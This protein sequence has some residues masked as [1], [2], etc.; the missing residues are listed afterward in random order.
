[1]TDCVFCKIVSGELPSSKIYEDDLCLAFLDI[2]PVNPGHT[3]LIP[4]KHSENFGSTPVETLEHLIKVAKKACLAA[5]S[6]TNA[7]GYNL[8]TSN[9]SAAGQEVMHLHFHIIPR[10]GGDGLRPWGHKAYS[11]DEKEKIAA[12]IREKIS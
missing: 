12:L 7:E 8:S 1:M 5:Q 9:G 11:G 3:L 4:K 10:A 6:A 2:R